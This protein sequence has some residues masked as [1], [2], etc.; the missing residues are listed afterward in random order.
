ME[1]WIVEEFEYVFETGR[2]EIL[3][4]FSTREKAAKFVAGK[5]PG[6][7]DLPVNIYSMVLDPEDEYE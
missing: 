4:L 3:G 7:F 6:Q 1:I 5:F 2:T